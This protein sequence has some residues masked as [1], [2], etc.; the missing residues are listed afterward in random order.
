MLPLNCCQQQRNSRMIDRECAGTLNACK[1][2]VFGYHKGRLQTNSGIFM[3]QQEQTPPTVMEQEFE[4]ALRSMAIA[5]KAINFYPET[6]PQ[7]TESITAA[8]RQIIPLVRD[9][10]LVLLWT[11]EGCT[12]IDNSAFT[13][14]SGTAKALALE[15]LKRKLKRLIIL[16]ELSQSDLQAFLALI[17]TDEAAIY[18][19]GGIEAEMLRVRITSIGANEVDLSL[20]QGVKEEESVEAETGSYDGEPDAEQ[21]EALEEGTE[22]PL[23]IQYSV[24][25]LD[26]IL[27]MMKGESSDAHFMQLAR[28]MIDAAEELKKR[29][30][31][32]ALLPALDALLDIHAEEL[33]P[34]SQKEFVRY[35]LEQ[36]IT[37]A[38]TPYL[39]DRIEERSA[40]NEALLD[41]LCAA[42]GQTLAYPL[43]QR[44][45]VAEALRSRKTIAIAL[46]RTG[47]AAIPA[48][49]PMLKDERWYVVRNMVTILGEIGSTEAVSAL[50]TAARHP[51]PKVRK[52]T[53][54]AFMKTNAHAA[55]H[56]LV[57]MMTDEDEE[58]VRQAIYSLGVCRSRAAVRPLL[59]I[60]TASDALLKQLV[61]K[62]HALAAIGKI[63]DRQATTAL[64]DIINSRGWLSPGRWQELK[65]AAAAALGQLGDESAIPAL[66][67]LGRRN[68][69]LGNACND[70][71]D[72]L[73]RLVK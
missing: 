51:E 32:D 41:K 44:L 64:L 49:L 67:K 2:S 45:C 36:I 28:E 5:L 61:L 46:T 43:I 30:A 27:G 14:R 6:H 31:F 52:E 19:A 1:I 42:I 50:Q 34:T 18:A 65:I 21:A 33:R 68:T 66:K 29:E 40:E 9:R 8:Y 59:G 10:E 55:E 24:L 69:P 72:N 15:M 56:T 58:V 63:G 48:L 57:S 73:E 7:R 22:E 37:G 62:K 71:A 12:C 25:G 47:E 53:I 35:T 16:P 54:K 17:T 70:A 39:L 4:S 60:V 26:I 20:I 11:R 38:M 23:D 13:S 3:E